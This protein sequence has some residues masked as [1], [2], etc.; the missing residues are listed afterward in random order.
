MP[1]LL[2]INSAI[3]HDLEPFA[4]V[5][6]I[7]VDLDGTL[8]DPKWSVVEFIQSS[9]P[10]LRVRG[11]RFTIATGRAFRGIEEVLPRLGLP[12]SMPLALYN[13]SLIV[14]AARRK[15]FHSRVIPAVVVAQAVRWG[16]EKGVPV[17]CYPLPVIRSSGLLESP[18][19]FTPDGYPPLHSEPNGYEVDWR[20]PKY[21]DSVPDCLAVLVDLRH[22]N[23]IM[24]EHACFDHPGVTVTQSSSSFLEFRP[25][26][27]DKGMATK[28]IASKL[29]V[30]LSAV[31]AIGDN[32]NDIEMLKTAGVSVSVG[33]AS[34][35]LQAVAAYNTPLTSAQGCIQIIRLVIAAHRYREVIMKNKEQIRNE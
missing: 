23:G 14:D 30:P 32:D 28:I 6:L 13:G 12:S 1:R 24:W 9:I 33:N 8:L 26:G 5:R 2:P 35:N 27:G 7:V 15:I 31:M 3:A 10:R 20:G 22:L 4:R 29:G 21:S 19:G 17:L 18:M 34:T 16:L 25:A 11:I